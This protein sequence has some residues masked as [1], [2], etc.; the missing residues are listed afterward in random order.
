MVKPH[1][2]HKAATLAQPT[3]LQLSRQAL[4]HNLNCVRENA[5]QANVMA[6]IKANAYG[7][8]M[9][10]MAEE[11]AALGVHRFGVATLAEGLLLRRQRE[12]EEIV[13]FGGASWLG[14]AEALVQ[15]RLTP[16]ITHL[17]ELEAL[18]PWVGQ[19]PFPV[20]LGLDTGMS[21]LGIYWE[22]TP[23]AALLPFID[24][25]KK[26]PQFELQALTT[27]FA[28]ADESAA[29]HLC[30][31]Q[32][33]RFNEGAEVFLAHGLAPKRFSIANSSGILRGYGKFPKGLSAH[34]FRI[35][36]D[37]R[38]GLMLYGLESRDEVKHSPLQ[39]LAHWR[40]PIVA[41]KRIKQGRAV[42]YG[43][44]HIC[45]KDTEIAVIGAGYGDGIPRLLSDRG[46]VMIDGC[47]A[48]ILGRICMDLFMVDV[49][50]WVDR[51]KSAQVA[52]GENVTLL[53]ADLS[54]ST[55]VEWARLAQTIPYEIMTSITA[56]VPRVWT[57]THEPLS[58]DLIP[59]PYLE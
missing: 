33:E 47:A 35:K 32:I 37:V 18:L 40:A 36:L 19:G 12:R 42:S 57:D 52:L 2:N 17:S 1:P 8:G 48:P 25:L 3:Y 5:P 23:A 46:Q 53:G 44:T 11:L 31:Q 56:R 58:L 6:M 28:K 24:F 22:D 7:H 21:R 55:V 16:L 30:E 14:R 59:L 51:D 45:Q 43:G 27:H 54:A 15:H 13:L 26:H 50:D 4:A 49:T 20:H 39:P 29:T 38:P 34:Q 9:C 41:R 10:L